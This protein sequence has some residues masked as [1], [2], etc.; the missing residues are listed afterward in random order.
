MSYDIKIL[1]EFLLF[2]SWPLCSAL[3]LAKFSLLKIP[4]KI[5]TSTISLNA[6]FLVKGMKHDNFETKDL[7]NFII[8]SISYSI[9]F[10]CCSILCS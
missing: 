6:Y 9:F 2:I 10:Y 8:T 5:E 1:V 3:L 7:K 4:S